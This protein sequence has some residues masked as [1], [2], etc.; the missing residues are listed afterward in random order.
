VHQKTNSMDFSGALRL[1]ILCNFSEQVPETIQ[2]IGIT[3]PMNCAKHTYIHTYIHI[4]EDV[5]TDLVRKTDRW[6]QVQQ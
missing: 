6:G 2:S 5:T 3:I 1:L 4:R